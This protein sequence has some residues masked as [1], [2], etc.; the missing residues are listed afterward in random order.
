MD[1]SKGNQSRPRPSKGRKPPKFVHLHPKQAIKAKQAWVQ[2]VKLRSEWAKQKR[3]LGLGGGGVGAS[4]EDEEDEGIEENIRASPGDDGKYKVSLK[5][6]NDVV[7][8]QEELMNSRPT[9]RPRHQSPTRERMSSHKQTE[10][11]L[12]N[13]ILSEEA[14]AQ[15]EKVRELTRQA[16]SKESLHTFKS[17]PLRRKRSRNDPTG[18]TNQKQFGSKGEKGRGQPN[19]KLRMNAL[20]EKIKVDVGTS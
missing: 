3:Q 5:R 19:M 18:N 9:K 12:V 17:D 11:P 8:E 20:L 16:Y 2:K 7:Y 15:R 10:K 1:S 13:P 4:R 6:R 14:K